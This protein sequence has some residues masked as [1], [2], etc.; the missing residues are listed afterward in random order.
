QVKAVHINMNI[1]NTYTIIFLSTTLLVLRMVF[2]LIDNGNFPDMGDLILI[3]SLV[4]LFAFVSIY[5]YITYIT[6]AALIYSLDYESN[7][8]LW[9]PCLLITVNSI[10]S[11]IIATLLTYEKLN[12]AVYVAFVF[13]MSNI[14]C[15]IFLRIKNQNLVEDLRMNQFRAASYTV[16]KR[17]TLKDNIRLAKD[18]RFFVFGSA[19][20]VSFYLPFFFLPQLLLDDQPAWR[21]TLEFSKALFQMLCA[22]GF[23]I[24]ELFVLLAFKKHVHF[25]KSVIGL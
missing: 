14:S 15:A 19:A 24:A 1:L 11:S 21:S 23:G 9:I 12:G 8:R 6:Y 20:Q 25:I 10:I 4:K 22:Y 2:V 17:W 3:V 18:T 16:S 13:C 5:N 7:R